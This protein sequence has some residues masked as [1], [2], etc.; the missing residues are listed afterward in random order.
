MIWLKCDGR[1]LLDMRRRAQRRDAC[2]AADSAWMLIFCHGEHR[3]S[4]PQRQ[5]GF[6]FACTFCVLFKHIQSREKYN[7][8]FVLTTERIIHNG[9][10]VSVCVSLASLV[11]TLATSVDAIALAR[12]RV[13]N[14][15]S[16]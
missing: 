9:R 6:A 1:T 2:A 13:L 3:A 4:S 12:R 5:R 14:S 10:A 7:V 11:G 16:A 8:H 15:K